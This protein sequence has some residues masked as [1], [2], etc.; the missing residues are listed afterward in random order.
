M[1]ERAAADASDFIAQCWSSVDAIPNSGRVAD[2]RPG[3]QAPRQYDS[4][5]AE[6][7]SLSDY[8]LAG[9]VGRNQTIFGFSASKI[10]L[11]RILA[12]SS[13]AI[14][15]NWDENQ[16][17]AVLKTTTQIIHSETLT[18][19]IWQVEILEAAGYLPASTV[20]ASHYNITSYNTKNG[21]GGN[22]TRVLVAATRGTP[23]EG[24]PD[25]PIHPH[26]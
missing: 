9:L 7:R 21:G 5:L 10:G 8:T 25:S 11:R 17:S 2:V 23:A 15:E 26:R 18:I 1:S 16:I 24:W 20:Y 3:M 19:N 14:P 4:G 22:C 12:G 13:V 6:D